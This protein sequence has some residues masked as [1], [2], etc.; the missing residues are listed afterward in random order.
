MTTPYHRLRTLRLVVTALGPPG[1]DSR[2]GWLRELLD[3]LREGDWTL[4][5]DDPPAAAYCV[6]EVTLLLEGL[7]R[8]F[9]G[10]ADV[11]DE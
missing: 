11:T 8:A 10:H 9:P 1:H 2:I 5:T 6:R 7:E 3:R 4:T